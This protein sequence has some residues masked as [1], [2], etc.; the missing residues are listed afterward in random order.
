MNEPTTNTPTAGND[1]APAVGNNPG[2]G[3]TQ[4]GG[5]A[6]SG[7][8]SA[9]VTFT[10]EQMAEANR[11]AD[12]RAQRATASALKAYFQQQGM[13]EEEAKGALAAYKAQKAKEKTPE[14]LAQEAAQNADARIGAAKQTVLRLSAQ[15]AA[16]AL[17]IKPERVPYALKLA[18][19]S[20][21]E[22][23][24]DMTADPQAV[25]AAVKKVLDDFPE[26]AGQAGPST[27]AANP[28]APQKHGGEMDAIRAAA[29]L[30]TT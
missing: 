29:G 23:G 13:S 7:N 1:P 21:V 20:G 2:A 4:P 17:G 9:G 8:P 22:V 25:T 16:S 27:P 11:I 3:S 15:A 24:D 18:D 30:K 28:Y 5:T 26:L 19:L 12:E 6:Q 14:Q 10:P